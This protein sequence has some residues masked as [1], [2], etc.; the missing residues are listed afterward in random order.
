MARPFRTWGYPLT[1]L[2]FLTVSAWALIFNFRGRP[3]ESILSLTT[4]LLGGAIFYA[5]TLR[6]RVSGDG[7]QPRK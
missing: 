5:T 1:P 3:L 2:L 6:K 7:P 4:V